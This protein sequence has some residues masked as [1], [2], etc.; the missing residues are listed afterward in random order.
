MME[1]FLKEVQHKT[2]VVVVAAGNPALRD[3]SLEDWHQGGLDAN[4]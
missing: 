3:S 1:N 4:D 2:G